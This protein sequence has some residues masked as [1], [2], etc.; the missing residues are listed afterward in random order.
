MSKQN[1]DISK[2]EQSGAPVKNIE[3]E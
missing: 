1:P 2:R 3:L